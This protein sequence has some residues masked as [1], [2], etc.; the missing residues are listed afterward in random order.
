[1]GNLKIPHD[2]IWSFWRVLQSDNYFERL[3]LDIDLADQ[4]TNEKV[5]QHYQEIK[6]YLDK[7]REREG[8]GITFAQSHEG[9]SIAELTV[10]LNEAYAELRGRSSRQKYTETHINNKKKK[11]REALIPTIKVAFSDGHLTN[12]ARETIYAEAGKMGLSPAETDELIREVG[13]Q[14]GV[15]K[16]SG[17]ES[18]QKS[19]DEMLSR[20][21]R[22]LISSKNISS[23]QIT[24]ARSPYIYERKPAGIS[25]KRKI[26]YISG[27]FLA[28]IVIL[29]FLYFQYFYKQDTGTQ[30]KFHPDNDMVLVEGGTFVM[31]SENEEANEKPARQVTLRSY[32]ISRYEVTQRLWLRVMEHNPSYFKGEDLPVDNVSWYDAILFCNKLSEYYGLEKVYSLK[33]NKKD[34]NNLS[35]YDKKKWVVEINRNANGYRLPTEAEWEYAARG[36]KYAD[37]VILSSGYAISSAWYQSNSGTVTHPVGKKE[38]NKLGICDIFGNVWEWCWDWSGPYNFSGNL[39]PAGP[40]SGENRICRGGSSNSYSGSLRITNRYGRYPGYKNEFFGF[41]IVRNT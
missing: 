35:K 17:N 20:E 26:Y 2:E 36:G 34:V 41:R 19:K 9:Y 13:S 6:N 40:E 8:A 3:F 33:V 31:G 7:W 22:S 30:K 5:S 11:I 16:I 29:C 1:S 24:V 18:S 27:T 15:K 37:E 4:I 12:N 14:P 38:P 25:T 21:A 32:M 23:A 10:K 28:L 39:N